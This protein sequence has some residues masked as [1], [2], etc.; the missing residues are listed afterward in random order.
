[1]IRFLVLLMAL[2]VTA[3]GHRPPA[4]MQTPARFQPWDA[5]LDEYRLR[6]GDEL[7]IR[8]LHNPEFS[9][10]VIVAPDGQI[11]MP[12]AGFVQA[13]GRTPR[14]LQA[15]LQARFRHELRQPEVSV[16]P[17]TFAQQRVFVGGEVGTPGVYD[18]PARI[19]VLQAVITAGG[20]EPTAR[21]DGVILIRRTPDNR[22]MM[23]LVD[24]EA[25]LERGALD[26]DVP[27]RPFDIVYVPRSDI[28]EANLFVEQFIRNL[29]PIQ[30]GIGYSLN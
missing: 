26:Q 28:A 11:S 1:M 20:F 4:E 2:L 19:G 9:D 15:I 8:L 23:R 5:S 13:A 3:C 18:L 22:A 17:R 7:D 25:I 12:L 21:E 10:R 14:E 29:L 30:P 24:V 6:P 27:L 16:I